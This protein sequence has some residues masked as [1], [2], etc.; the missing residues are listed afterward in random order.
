[1]SGNQSH[2]IEVMQGGVF[3]RAKHNW[4]YIFSLFFGK[5]TKSKQNFY[6][7]DIMQFFSSDATMFLEKFWI[8]FCPWKY[9]K[10]SSKVA[11][12]RPKM[13]FSVLPKSHILFHKNGSMRDFY[14]MT[15]LET[16]L[17]STSV[18]HICSTY[19]YF[20]TFDISEGGRNYFS[21]GHFI[22]LHRQQ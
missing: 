9:E 18:P 21:Y 8:Y 6:M 7:R 15:L 11:H 13:F 17:E 1:M 3:S 22:S 2:Y 19:S 12:N 20:R 5:K 4:L 14:K 16:T 10:P